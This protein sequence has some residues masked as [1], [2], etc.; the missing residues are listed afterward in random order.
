V[1]AAAEVGIPTL[2]PA[3]TDELAADDAFARALYHC[4]MNVHVVAGQLVCPATGRRFPIE[5][6]IPNMI[7]QEDECEAVRF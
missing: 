2:P 1:Q 3:L 4:L 7:L 6:E 5:N